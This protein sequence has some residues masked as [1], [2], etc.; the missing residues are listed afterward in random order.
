[1]SI[2]Q[3][4]QRCGLAPSAIRYYERVGLLPRPIRVNRRRRYDAEAIGRVRFV[5]L[6]R[7][8]GFTIAETRTL[9]AGFSATTPP[10]VRWRT[11]A[12]RK[13][14]DI[15]TQIER[16]RGMKTLLET[17]FDCRCLSVED[18]ARIMA[19]LPAPASSKAMPGKRDAN[20]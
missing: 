7:E 8:A 17:G 4:A 6:A 3:V 2:G 18:C 11:L 20:S 19:R 16:L 13:L 5:L 10:A 9:V 1:M 14:V 15:E 12:E